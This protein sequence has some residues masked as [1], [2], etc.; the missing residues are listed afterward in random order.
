MMGHESNYP[1]PMTHDCIGNNSHEPFPPSSINHGHVMKSEV[2][3]EVLCGLFIDI[4]QPII[5][6]AIDANGL[7]FFHLF[8]TFLK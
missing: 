2:L 4:I 6:A 5:G 8:S 3:A 7:N 1:S